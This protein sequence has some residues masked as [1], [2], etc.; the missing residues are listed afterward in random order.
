MEN[1]NSIEIIKGTEFW[2]SEIEQAGL[3]NKLPFFNDVITETR[4]PHV[5]AGYGKP[6][7]IDVILDS[8]KSD[9]YHTD[10]NGGSWHRI[11][12]HIKE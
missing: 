6:L 4:P 2:K 7:L 3:L 11:F 1:L 12:I 9:I 10:W 8:K 5:D